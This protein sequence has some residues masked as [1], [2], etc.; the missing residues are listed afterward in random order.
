M[1]QFNQAQQSHVGSRLKRP[2]NVGEL[3]HRNRAYEA[4]A[5]SPIYIERDG[6]LR[7]HEEDA[8]RSGM[9]GSASAEG[10]SSWSSSP[11]SVETASAT[12][13]S[14]SSPAFLQQNGSPVALTSEKCREVDLTLPTPR[15]DPTMVGNGIRFGRGDDEFEYRAKGTQMSLPSPFLH[16]DET[17][18]FKAVI[19]PRQLDF[20]AATPQMCEKE[21]LQTP[22]DVNSGE[23]EAQQAVS[24]LMQ[25][26]EE[27]LDLKQRWQNAEANSRQKTNQV[28]RK[29]S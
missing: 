22:V 3:I 8:D 2:S 27:L 14:K 13:F 28:P 21:K 23:V 9:H 17:R 24:L 16:H 19:R 26:R 18:V 25:A 1:A 4:S 5:M 7:R 29:T 10:Q 15:L 20:G 12:P 6:K 11:Y